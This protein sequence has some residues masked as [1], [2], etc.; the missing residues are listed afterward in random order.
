MKVPWKMSLQVYED[1]LNIIE[2]LA[3]THPDYEY[4][5][6]MELREEL[7]RLDGFPRN[8][9]PEYDIVVPVLNQPAVVV[10]VPDGLE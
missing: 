4:E 8:L 2:E 9:D 5:K 7:R 10:N 6:Y 3:D 1:Y